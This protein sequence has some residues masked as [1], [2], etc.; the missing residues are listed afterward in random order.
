[1]NVSGASHPVVLMTTA[2]FDIQ[3]MTTC[4]RTARTRRRLHGLVPTRGRRQCQG[5]PLVAQGVLAS[6]LLLQ[7]ALEAL[8]S[9]VARQLW[10]RTLATRWLVG[11][12]LVSRAALSAQ[13]VTRG[14][15]T[16]RRALV[17]RRV[18]G[19]ALVQKR[20]LG[21]ASSAQWATGV[22]LAAQQASGAAVVA[23]WVPGAAVGKHQLLGAAQVVRRMQMPTRTRLPLWTLGVAPWTA[24]HTVPRPAGAAIVGPRWRTPVVASRPASAALV[25]VQ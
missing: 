20:A 8:W 21:E 6:R 16:I 11:D 25:H 23:S 9:L 18:S 4:P 12:P 10:R 22:A 5:I 17:P 15:L 19:T 2:T 14:M 24:A 7:R 13:S 1:M 3:R